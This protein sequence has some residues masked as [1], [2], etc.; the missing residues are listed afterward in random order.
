MTR[1][2]RGATDPDTR[3]GSAM[4]VLTETD[5]ELVDAVQIN[6]RA[7]WAAIGSALGLSPVTAARHWKSLTASGAAWTCATMGSDWA[8]GAFVELACPHGGTDEIVRLLCEMPEVLTVG[9]TTGDFDLYVI[10]VS[11]TVQALRTFLFETI[12]KLEVRRVRSHVYSQIF[13]GPA[14]RLRVLNR[15]TAARVREES[16]RQL[17]H[18]AVDPQDRRLFLALGADARRP[19]PELAEELGSTPQAVRRRMDR[20]RRR[21]QI[22]FRADMAR[23]LAGFPLAA[24]L[25][26]KVPDADVESVGRDLGRWAEVRFCA[27]VVSAANLVL[28]VNLRSPEHLDSF[29]GKLFSTHGGVE[30]ADRRLVLRLEKVHG[31]LLDSEGR[32]RRVVPV[33]PWAGQAEGPDGPG[34]DRP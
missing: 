17:P 5:L 7:S 3:E 10:S 24:L 20:M 34:P 15:T 27:P 4:D 21:D 18:T 12:A 6:P 8:R 28:I 14:W 26:L 29:V 22:A 25:W 31:H 11:P 33:D 23:P 16:P 32:S 30:I 1:E 9:R 2:D 19:Y 13:G